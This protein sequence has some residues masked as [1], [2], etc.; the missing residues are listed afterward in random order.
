MK[1]NYTNGL[2]ISWATDNNV[3]ING[4]AS[5]RAPVTRGFPQGSVI[6]P[7]MFMVYAIDINNFI[8]K[9][10]D[11][12]EIGNSFFS[13][14]DCIEFQLGLLDCRYPLEYI[15]SHVFWFK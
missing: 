12:S 6:G 14:Q 9:F 5:E 13:D 8:S 15:K 7:V 11:D 2:L 3:G 1:A 4:A 10:A